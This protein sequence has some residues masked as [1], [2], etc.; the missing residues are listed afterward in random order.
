VLCDVLLCAAVLAVHAAHADVAEQACLT[1]T[2]AVHMLGL[3][4]VLHTSVHI[5]S[6]CIS[7]PWAAAYT[8]ASA[9]AAATVTATAAALPPALQVSPLSKLPLLLTPCC[10]S[11]AAIACFV[12]Y[13]CFCCCCIPAAPWLGELASHASQLD[14]RHSTTKHHH[15]T[16]LQQHTVRVPAAA[17]APAAHG[18]QMHAGESS[19]ASVELQQ[20]QLLQMI[21]AGKQKLQKPA[22]AAAATLHRQALTRQSSKTRQARLTVPCS[23]NSSRPQQIQGSS[24]LRMMLRALKQL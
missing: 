22:V 10:G 20:Q 9:H 8:P 21:T 19:G 23:N 4:V 6:F 14:H 11:L 2:E 15:H 3:H 7:G 13:F 1:A 17:A 18:S 16:H 5:H 24:T 12:P